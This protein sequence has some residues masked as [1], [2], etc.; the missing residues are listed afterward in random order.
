MILEH[1]V[2]DAPSMM[3]LRGSRQLSG[4]IHN[5]YLDPAARLWVPLLSLVEAERE[6]AGLLAHVGQIDAFR[7]VDVDYATAYAAFELVRGE[8]GGLALGQA[9]AVVAARRLE[10]ECPGDAVLIATVSPGPYEG[11]GA[12]VMDLDR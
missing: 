10:H 1:F 7:T 4:L 12:A 9:A 5:A 8:A 6:A 11:L 2:L 3:A